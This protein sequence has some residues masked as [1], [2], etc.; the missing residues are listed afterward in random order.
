MSS[1]RK[2]NRTSKQSSL[3]AGA[4]TEAVRAVFAWGKSFR[5][6]K[7]VFSIPEN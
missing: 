2:E 7:V 6:R 5:L 3:A 1:E 4:M